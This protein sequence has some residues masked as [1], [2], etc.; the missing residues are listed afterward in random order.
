M[1]SLKAGRPEAISSRARPPMG[2]EARKR[3]R[4]ILNEKRWGSGVV[5]A[6]RSSLGRQSPAWEL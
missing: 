2:L 6:P 4:S 5:W 1:D 3:E